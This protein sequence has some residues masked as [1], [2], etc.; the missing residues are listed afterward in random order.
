MSVE[1]ENYLLDCEVARALAEAEKAQH[2]AELAKWS[3]KSA[4]VAYDTEYINYRSQLDG[5][6]SFYRDVSQKSC[7]KLMQ[8]MKMWHDVDPEGPWTIY[9]N[10]VGGEI[11]PGT[12]LLDELAVHSL[13]RGGSHE[14]TIKV[15]GEAASMAGILLQAGDI[16]LIGPTSLLMIHEPMSG[17]SGSLHDIRA[18]AEWLERYWVTA[19]ELFAERSTM[20][21]EEIRVTAHK[22]DWWLT[23]KE[24]CRLG[25]ADAIG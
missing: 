19:S 24:S 23:A 8:A 14:I 15:R 7:N 21:S 10:S 6:Y 20:T 13:R 1:E 9:L 5:T 12:A 4:K 11:I 25:F 3:A 17:V 16:R 18:E 2:E 22:Q